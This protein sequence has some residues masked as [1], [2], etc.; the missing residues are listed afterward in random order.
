MPATPR[1]RLSGTLCH[2]IPIVT[3]QASTNTETP[4]HLT[5]PGLCRFSCQQRGQSD[6]STLGTFK[7]TMGK[8]TGKRF[9]LGGI[10]QLLI[11]LDNA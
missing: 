10:E 11:E 7:Q 8:A 9:C 3:S 4:L 6:S 2:S 1:H 5:H